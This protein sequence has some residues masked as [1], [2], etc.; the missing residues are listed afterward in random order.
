MHKRN[1]VGGTLFHWHPQRKLLPWDGCRGLPPNKG[2]MLQMST[3]N[4]FSLISCSS[5]KSMAPPT[6]H[7]ATVVPSLTLRYE[8]CCC[9]VL[10]KCLGTNCCSCT[11]IKHAMLPH[12]LVITRGPCIP[13]LLSMDESGERGRE[14]GYP[15]LLQLHP[16]LVALSLSFVHPQELPLMLLL[17]LLHS[18]SSV[19]GLAP[20]SSVV[21]SRGEQSV[22]R[23]T[24]IG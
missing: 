2:N 21:R 10:S 23:G 1:R 8:N 7:Q 12:S 11:Y 17:C 3:F 13:L 22:S 6:H 19:P 14:E 15:L 20:S 18:Q 24:R 4:K 16:L 9:P 5:F